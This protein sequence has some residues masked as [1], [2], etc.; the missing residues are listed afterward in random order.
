MTGSA[1]AFA[2]TGDASHVY[3]YLGQMNTLAPDVSEGGMLSEQRLKEDPDLARAISTF[4]AMRTAEA[5][6][7]YVLCR[8]LFPLCQQPGQGMHGLLESAGGDHGVN[9]LRGVFHD[10]EEFHFVQFLR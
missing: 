7:A 10:V 5:S 2:E 6:R 1:L 4:N 3:A 8:I 9:F